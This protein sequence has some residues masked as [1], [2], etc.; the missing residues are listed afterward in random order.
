MGFRC[1]VHIKDYGPCAKTVQDWPRA[2][3]PPIRY[4]AE[5]GADEDVRG[6]LVGR[7]PKSTERPE[8]MRKFASPAANQQVS[9]TSHR[10]SMIVITGAEIVI[11]DGQRRGHVKTRSC[12]RR[13]M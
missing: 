3:R 5:G 12:K 6:G 8:L 11:D 4:G 9:A 1:A 10:K 7:Y 2:A 13:V